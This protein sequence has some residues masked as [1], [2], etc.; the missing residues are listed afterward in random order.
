M[1]KVNSFKMQTLRSIR[2]A[3]LIFMPI[4]SL[5]SVAET[6]NLTASFTPSPTQPSNNTFT[7]TTP[8]SGY[9][10]EQPGECSYNN[11]FSIK[12]NLTADKLLPIEANQD[13]QRKGAM[14]RVPAA[15]RKAQVT[16]SLGESYDLEFRI[17]GIGATQRFTTTVTSITG[18]ES[19]QEAHQKLWEGDG[20]VYGADNCGA[21]YSGLAFVTLYSYKFFWKKDVS[22]AICSR[23]ALFRIPGLGFDTINISYE[24]RTPE[25]LSMRSGDYTGEMDFSIGNGGDFD[26]GDQM[27]PSDTNLHVHFDLY[28][29][30]IL[31]IRFP[32][33]AN[34]LSLNPDGGWQ[35]W[36][37]RGRR[38]EK[39]AANQSFEIWSSGQFKMLLE[40]QYPVANQCGI[41]NEGGDLVPV[42]TRVTLPNGLLD[43]G[44]MAVNR[45]LLSNSNPSVFHNAQYVQNGRAALDFE[46]SRDSVAQMTSYAGSRYSGNVTIVWDS[47]I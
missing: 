12:L 45:Y 18:L 9:C 22:D 1:I 44:E 42:E 6:L 8:V 32:P 13:D 3:I 47:D 4:V 20:W 31:D 15:W 43:E 16:N 2:N 41:Q 36:L 19:Y 33:N 34:I 14:I 23:K 17:S 38:P 7:N 25:P 21:S 24:L 30:H 26:F 46:V 11:V 37:Y 27:S 28:V 5:P 35:Q 29:N 40:C 10:A 39:L